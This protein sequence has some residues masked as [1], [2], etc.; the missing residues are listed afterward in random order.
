MRAELKLVLSVSWEERM[1]CM[2]Q[3][4]DVVWCVETIKEQAKRVC[5]K[6]LFVQLYVNIFAFCVLG[7]RVTVVA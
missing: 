6:V 5:R 7:L 3:F 1:E 4:Y 2:T